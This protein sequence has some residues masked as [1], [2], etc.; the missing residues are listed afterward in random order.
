MT[1]K[2]IACMLV[3][4]ASFTATQTA[5]AQF[6]CISN[7]EPMVNGMP[8]SQANAMSNFNAHMNAPNY[9]NQAWQ[10]M[11]P[12]M[13]YVPQQAPM[14]VAPTGYYHPI[15]TPQPGYYPTSVTPNYRDPGMERWQQQR[16][17]DAR[18]EYH[19]ATEAQRRNPS[20]TGAMRITAAE[21]SLRNVMYGQ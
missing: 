3:A 7:P 2:M 16:V 9:A 18:R 13:N 1:K 11:Q 20:V 14:P 17:N 6:G 10:G 12:M 8:L 21:Q 15:P 19:K 4:F 5:F